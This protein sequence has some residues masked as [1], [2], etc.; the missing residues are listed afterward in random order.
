MAVLTTLAQLEQVQS[1]ITAVMSG[2]SYS[3]GDVS[4]TR[5][6]L[7]AL[8]VRETALL[9]RYAMEQR[10]GRRIRPNFSNGI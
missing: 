10:G 1:A 9:E 7:A 5:A 4:F 3:V 8:Q 2:Q 6:N